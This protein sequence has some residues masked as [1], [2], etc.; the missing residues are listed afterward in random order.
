LD[1]LVSHSRLPVQWNPASLPFFLAAALSAWLVSLAWGRRHEPSA[2]SLISL[3]FFQGLWALCEAINVVVFDPSAQA[4][5]YCLKLSSVALLPPSLL[6][7]VLDYTNRTGTSPARFKALILVVPAMCIALILTS[8]KHSLFLAGLDQVDVGGYLLPSARY[9]PAFWIHTSYSYALLWLSAWL[10]TRSALALSGLLRMQMLFLSACLFLPMAINL[11]DMLKIIPEPYIHYDITAATF[12]VTGGLGFVLLRRFQLIEVAPVSYSLVVHEMLDAI[13][14]LDAR[15]RIAG[16]NRAA[17]HLMGRRD[18]DIVGLPG[19]TIPGWLRI[20]EHLSKLEGGAELSY[21]LNGDLPDPESAFDVRVSRFPHGREPGWL[22]IVRD[23]SAQSR[24]EGERTARIAAEQANLAK[25]AFLAKLGHELRTPLT[26][27]LAIVSAALDQG[28]TPSELRSSLEVVQRNVRLEARL[29]D[30]L[31]DQSLISLG[32]LRLRMELVDAHAVLR[33]SLEDCALFLREAGLIARLDL[34]ATNSRIVADQGRLQQVFWNLITNAAR[35]SPARSHLTIRTRN[36]TPEA[37]VI[38]FQDEGRGVET[39]KLDEIFEPFIQ[40]KADGADR[41][42]GLGLGLSIGRWIVE[43]HG[44]TLVAESLG[45]GRGT[46]FRAVLFTADVT[47]AATPDRSGDTSAT[48]LEHASEQPEAA[49]N[50]CRPTRILL[51]EDNPDSLRALS[52]SLSLLGYEVRPANSLRTA[53]AAVEDGEYDLIVSDLELGD[54]TGLD[55]LRSTRPAHSTPAIAL[56]G[57]GSEED[58]QMCLEAGFDMHLTKPVETRQ[59]GEA[60]RNIIKN[61]SIHS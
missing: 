56:T 50:S 26:P 25:D 36:R 3:I 55:L 27:V 33:Q 46:T 7:F 2:L 13:I 23:I 19:D 54:G 32:K 59:L 38:E 28:A 30:D 12:V 35:N 11:A 61:H 51:V 5:I 58:R 53:L 34:S 44:G 57:Y 49:C 60:I 18:K 6:F 14:V 45:P 48:T 10:L 40:G 8:G 22:V 43:A 31:L 21:R 1:L 42:P 9:G 4:I 17:L 37:L 52:M 16:V 39:S 41:Q 29:I 24:G 47:E 20:P 15:R